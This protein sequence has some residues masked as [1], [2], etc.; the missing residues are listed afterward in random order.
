MKDHDSL[1]S[2]SQSG[3]TKDLIDIFNDIEARRLNISRGI[4]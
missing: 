2:V 3:E 4:G 1:I